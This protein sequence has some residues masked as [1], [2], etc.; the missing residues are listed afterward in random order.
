M[1][2]RYLAGPDKKSRYRQGW[3]CPKHSEKYVGDTKKITYRSFLEFRAM[4]KLD[5]DPTI[6]KWASEEIWIPYVNPLDKSSRLYFVDLFFEQKRNG[7]T[8]KFLCEVKPWLQTQPPKSKG[9]RLLKESAT[10]A[11]N[12]SKWQAATKWAKEHGASFIIWTERDL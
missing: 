2:Q 7:K 11:V 10:L 1:K 4:A 9:K 5:N 6:V 12:L 8:Q 3:F